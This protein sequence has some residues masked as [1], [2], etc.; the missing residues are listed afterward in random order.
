MVAGL[1]DSA[2]HTSVGPTAEAWVAYTSKVRKAL[3]KA[4][5]EKSGTP[6]PEEDLESLS[7]GDGDES[8]DE[9]VELGAYQKA[10][11][12][13]APKDAVLEVACRAALLMGKLCGDNMPEDADM[14]DDEARSLAREA[15]KLVTKYMAALFGPMHTTK[16]HRLAY[17]LHDEFVL[18]GNVVD[19]DTSVNEMMH[20]L[21]T[22]MYDRSNKS[23]D[24][25]ML[26]MLRAEQT[27]AFVT[28]EDDAHEILRAADLLGANDDLLDA[29]AE[30]QL[31]T[32]QNFMDG[33]STIPAISGTGGQGGGQ[34]PQQARNDGSDGVLCAGSGL[35][36][37]QNGGN[38]GEGQ[39][40][41]R[42]KKRRLGGA[43][44][45]RHSP[46]GVGARANSEVRRRLGGGHSDQALGN[47][48]SEVCGRARGQARGEVRGRARGQARGRAHTRSAPAASRAYGLR[49]TVGDAQDEHGGELI[50]LGEL[51]QLRRSQLLT[52][53]NSLPFNAT[54]SWRATGRVQHVRASD[55]LYRS[56]WWDHVVYQ[57]SVTAE[58][59][60]GRAC[61]I[62][63][64]ID[65]APRV[66]L[67]VQ[68]MIRAEAQPHC[69][70][71]KFGCTRL[72]WEVDNRTGFPALHAVRVEDLIRLE[73]IVPDF[74]DLCNRH[75]LFVF[76]GDTPL[77]K[78]ER[79]AERYW[80]NIFYPW[81]SNGL[82][83]D[84]AA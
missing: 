72:R 76:P 2:E 57:D 83:V 66:L 49:V 62:I 42:G 35:T 51:L 40:N 64:G 20:K 3:R 68:R 79:V 41:A 46:V 23:V 31:R 78:A 37:E 16:M 21:C 81:T 65:A 6:L 27:L 9:G 28:A 5:E 84:K 60:H 52:V 25:F 8:G 69:V 74:E 43:L 18:R 45:Q 70:L 54:F 19:A 17:H 1:I 32:E 12:S 73:H 48:R 58:I 26:Q 33:V 50:A 44:V 34:I 13:R 39:E 47:M 22:I 82:R 38:P 63:K 53:T 4:K 71:T 80:V 59:R 77:T 29:T 67:V 61:L 15:Y 36:R 14:T 7:E 24:H 30:G 55:D 75:G 10:F 11:G 56:P